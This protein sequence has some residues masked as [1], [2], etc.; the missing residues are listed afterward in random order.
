MLEAAHYYTELLKTDSTRG[1]YIEAASNTYKS[2]GDTSKALQVLQKG[3]KHLP[4]DNFL[5]LDEAN[6]YNNRKDYHALAHTM[7]INRAHD[8]APG[9]LAAPSAGD[10]KGD[11]DDRHRGPPAAHPRRTHDS[12]SRRLAAPRSDRV[13][14]RRG[15]R[16]H[17]L[18]ASRVAR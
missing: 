3:R 9:P 10:K 18:W 13:L 16:G 1:Q 6:I 11:Y 7:R 15:V 12:A 14:P 17:P 8:A 4:G 5:L 2:I